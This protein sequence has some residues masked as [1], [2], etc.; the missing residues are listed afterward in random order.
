[1][2]IE[3]VSSPRSGVTI[4]LASHHLFAGHRF[5]ITFD[6]IQQNSVAEESLAREVQREQYRGLLRPNGTS[7]N[8]YA[9]RVLVKE[10]EKRQAEQRRLEWQTR[11]ATPMKEP[12][13][14]GWQKVRSALKKSLDAKIDAF[15]E[16]V[17]SFLSDVASS[18]QAPKEETSDHAR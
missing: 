2:S 17:Y 6:A 10:L 4:S 1:M 16:R 18:E 8:D 7:Y 15:A 3:I 14:V 13:T 12:T 5:S 11:G 9:T